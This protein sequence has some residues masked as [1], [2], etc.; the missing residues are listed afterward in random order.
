MFGTAVGNGAAF[1]FTT[2]LFLDY[3]E[4]T[5]C[6]A[7]VFVRHGKGVQQFKNFHVFK[8]LE[9]AL[10][11]IP[12]NLAMFLDAFGGR[13][14]GE[15]DTK[16][17]GGSVGRFRGGCVRFRAGCVGFVV[18]VGWWRWRFKDAAL[19]GCPGCISGKGLNV[20]GGGS[21]GLHLGETKTVREVGLFAFAETRS[22]LLF[23]GGGERR[24]GVLFG[25]SSSW[26]E[27]GG[28]SSS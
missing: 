5:K 3:A 22:A 8:L 23:L 10:E 24:R 18:G 21:G 9:L 2:A 25:C 14:L 1:D 16:V 12:G 26:I 7:L 13:H 6:F 28:R 17:E 20:F 11:R 19:E 15:E 27:V 4:C